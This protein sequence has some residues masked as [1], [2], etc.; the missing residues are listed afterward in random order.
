[1]VMTDVLVVLGMDGCGVIILSSSFRT[2]LSLTLPP[3]SPRPSLAQQQQQQ[4]RPNRTSL[5]DRT[6]NQKPPNLMVMHA[7][8][9]TIA[10]LPSATTPPRCRI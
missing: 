4:Q 3:P 8:I 10:C 9:V 5:N 6:V 7:T 1:M 2:G